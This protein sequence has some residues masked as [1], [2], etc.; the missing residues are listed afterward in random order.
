VA[1][2]QP[3]TTA[4][5]PGA[6]PRPA[7]EIRQAVASNPVWYHSVELGQGIVTPGRVDMRPVAKRILPED[8]TGKR[9]LDV[10][11]FDGFWAFELERRGADVVAIDVD[12]IEAAEWPP[13]SRERLQRDSDAFGVELGRGFEIAS[14]TLGSSVRKVI[15]NVYDVS[16]E[17]VGGPVDFAF[18]GTIMLHLRDPVKALERI[19]DSLA[20]GGELRIIEPFSWRTTLS[21]PRRP[22]ADFRAADSDFNWWVPNLA[23]LHAWLRAAGFTDVQRLAVL[24]P[25]SEARMRQPYAAYSARRPE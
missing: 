2:E 17:A 8:L 9:A 25:P 19:R 4:A 22:A 15:C 1:A 16:S 20:P 3:S 12:K 24:R 14:R 11:T 21:S 5:P 18:S 6:E 13:L 7:A 23:A 10:G